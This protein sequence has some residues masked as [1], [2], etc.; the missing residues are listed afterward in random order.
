VERVKQTLFFELTRT[1][2]HAKMR[3]I[4]KGLDLMEDSRRP[5]RVPTEET[6]VVIYTDR[7]Q[8]VGSI[9]IPQRGRI[10]DFLNRVAGGEDRALFIPVTDARVFS[11]MDESLIYQVEYLALNKRHV[12]L[13]AP[14]ADEGPIRPPSPL[15]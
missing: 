3:K 12:Y 10:T 13:I 2:A 5:L 15:G 14:F 7:F 8:I 1:D 11:L 9:H 6:Q 4:P